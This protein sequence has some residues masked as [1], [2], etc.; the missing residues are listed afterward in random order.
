MGQSIGQHDS[1]LALLHRQA[2]ALALCRNKRGQLNGRLF[3]RNA[4]RAD[5]GAVSVPSG[6]TVQPRA[7]S[8]SSSK[9]PQRASRTAVLTT[10]SG[11]EARSSRYRTASLLR[12]VSVAI[13]VSFG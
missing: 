9:A 3:Q 7:T 8:R 11:H 10:A 2:R 4:Q 1:F 5:A 13:A 12:P 6:F